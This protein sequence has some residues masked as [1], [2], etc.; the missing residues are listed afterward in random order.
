MSGFLL[1]ITLRRDYWDYWL[2]PE[3]KAADFYIY[4]QLRYTLF[5]IFLLLWC[6]DGLLLSALSLWSALSSRRIVRWAYRTLIL[7]FAFS[8]VLILGGS[9]MLLA[10]NAGWPAALS[11]KQATES[12]STSQPGNV[13]NAAGVVGVILPENA[14]TL[15][16]LYPLGTAYWTPSV[17]DV[18]EAETRLE[19]FLKASKHPQVPEILQNLKTYKRQY[20]G[21]LEGGQKFLVVRFFCDA[22]LK[23][24]TGQEAVILDGGPCFFNVRYSI[25]T[26]TFSDLEINGYA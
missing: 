9:L 2:Y 1:W 12:D 3:L 23:D 19:P 6:L 21:I 25:S 16:N 18:L 10:R 20:R 13:I 14:R 11:S 7:Y 17:A 26:K 15:Q 24:L 4:P 5:D 8:I 22:P